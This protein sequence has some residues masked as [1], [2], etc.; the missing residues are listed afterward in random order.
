MAIQ[1]DAFINQYLEELR[2]NVELLD[3][4]VIALKKDPGNDEELNRILRILHTIK[5][6]SR[7]L[8][9]PTIEKIAHGLESVFKG[10]KEQ[11]FPVS[12]GITRLSFLASD[13][14][15]EGARRIRETKIDDIDIAEIL[16]TLTKAASNEPFTLPEPRPQPPQQ[17][18]VAAEAES[19]TAAPEA[20]SVFQ[21]F[22]TIR[23]RVDHIDEI[24]KAMNNLI[25]SQFQL[26]KQ[27]DLIAQ[28]GKKVELFEPLNSPGGDSASPRAEY[29][30]FGKTLSKDIQKIRKTLH[31]HLE[32]I[33]RGTFGLQEMI[34][35]LRMFPLHMIL[36][37]L[38][39][40]VE[41]LS[42]NLNKKIRFTISG[43]DLKLEKIILETVND[44]IIHIVRNAVDHG[45]ESPAARAAAGKDETA[46][47]SIACTS[48]SGA[49][50]V[51]VQDDGGGISYGQVRARAKEMFPSMSEEIQN[52]TEAELAAY[53]FMPGFS[54]S[55]AV[56]DIS[57]RG[58]GLDIV[59]HNIEKIKGK[60]TISSVP[61]KGTAVGMTLPMSLATIN[62]YFITAASLR[63][64]I[65]SNFV[66]EI[67]LIRQND[68]IQVLNRNAFMLRGDL[69]HLYPLAHI[70]D[71]KAPAPDDKIRVLLV[72]SLGTVIGIA[73]DS[74]IEYASL[75]YKP[76]PQ[77]LQKHRFVQG[78]VFDESYN[79]VT[80]LH[81]PAL[82]DMCKGMSDMEVKKR[83]ARSQRRNKH[84]LVID[85][86]ANSREIQK[87]ILETAHFTV[88]TAQDGIDGLAKMRQE[89]FHLIITDISMPRMDGFT[90][91]ENVRREKKY[92]D[93]PIIVVSNVED[94]ESKQRAHDLGA[95][96]Y[97]VKSDFDRNNLLDG[98]H[99]LLG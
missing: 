46:T 14:F 23:I 22:Q 44:P 94:A 92:H 56:S 37:S 20:G 7:M 83:Y 34:I 95:N 63:F 15:Q 28:L 1:R 41:E 40:M 84:I 29:D 51:T 18:A 33:E 45:I 39:K 12:E 79:I 60:I 13:I 99:N 69:I 88:N 90:F 65:P 57:G 11:R 52:M 66:R 26:K 61:G 8:K 4:S 31:E 81:I 19:G 58:V 62:G 77:N 5:G 68:T 98:V 30:R 27:D 16:D 96:R 85:D 97:I 82:I 55:S 9:F 59:K 25:I 2:E 6:S 24:I 76:L 86:S 91:I 89:D 64:F 32:S 36:G 73:V 21:E 87:S 48:E 93:I 70:L 3:G 17:A 67:L 72:E 80:I 10:I 43:G 35:G 47:I 50:L 75:I 49:I 38:P 54:T 74:I 42:L 71:I 53:L 78:I